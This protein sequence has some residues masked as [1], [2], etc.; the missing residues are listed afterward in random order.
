M[1]RSSHR[2]CSITKAFLK[3]N[4]I[5]EDII[6]LYIY[7]FHFGI[8]ILSKSCR[9][10]MYLKKLFLKISQISQENTF[11]RVSF[12]S[13]TSNLINEETTAQCLTVL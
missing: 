13:A 8:C 9:T 4:E 10:E 12:L 5:A 7:S 2:R 3:Q 11:T 1:P 6:M